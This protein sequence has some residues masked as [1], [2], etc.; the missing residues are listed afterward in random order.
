MVAGWTPAPWRLIRNRVLHKRSDVTR[1]TRSAQRPSA[2]GG[3]N[4]VL[5]SSYAGGNAKGRSLH[6]D[7]ISLVKDIW[8]ATPMRLVADESTASPLVPPSETVAREACSGRLEQV[9]RLRQLPLPA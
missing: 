3:V 8:L 1:Q 7:Q 9:D 5:A 4:A 6:E 2:S